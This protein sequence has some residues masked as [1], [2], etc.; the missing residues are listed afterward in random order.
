MS[1]SVAGGAG[2][3]AIHLIVSGTLAVDGTLSANGLN[4]S[5][6]YAAPAGGGSGGSIWIEAATL[7]G[8]T[9]GKIQANG[10]NGL[11]EHAGYSS[12]GSGGRIAINVTSNSFNGNGQVQ[13]Y[14][15]GGLARGGAGTIYWAPEKRLVIDNNGNNGQAAGLVEGNYDTST[16]SQIQLTRYGH[17]KVLGAASSLALENGMVGG[18]GTAVLENYGAVTTPTNFTVSGYIF[19]PQMAFPAITNLIVESNGTV[20][21]YAGLGQ[22]QGTFTFDNV[23]VGENS[24]LVLA[25]WNDSDSD[26]SDDYGVVLTVNQDLSILSTG[27]ITADGTGYRG[28]QGFGA[29]AAGGG[30]IGASGGGYGGYGGSGQS[31]QAGGSP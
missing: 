18:D 24:T 21:L 2:G 16:L 19:S 28:G 1:G 22:P 10:G 5:T 27:K 14:G 20:R 30:S 29:G 23:S 8:A 12:G 7:I 11:P 4:G 15:G 9:T 26:Y 13:S 6:A 17:L 31:G 25:S 3:G